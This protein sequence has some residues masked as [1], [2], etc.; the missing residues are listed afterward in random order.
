MTIKKINK[1]KSYGI[2]KDFRW[3]NTIPEFKKYNIINMSKSAKPKNTS[4]GG[5]AEWYDEYL[6]D[7]DTYQEKVIL[8]NLLRVLSLKRGD[9]VIDIACG[10]GYF[11]DRFQKAGAG[12]VGADI[13]KEL[14]A[15][16]KKRFPKIQFHCAPAEKLS[17]AKN[18]VFDIATIILAVQNIADIRGTFRETARIL[19]PGGRL[20]LVMNHPAFR[21]P[22]RSSW[23]WDEEEKIQYRRMDGYLSESS[24]PILAH[25]GQRESESTLSYHRSLQD[26]FK[27]FSKAGFSATRLEEWVSH[28]QSE[29]GPRQKAEN[30][31]RAEFPLFLMLEAK[32]S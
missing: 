25:P 27:A 23:G 21:I 8:P 26:F 29:K 6:A 20:V 14:I 24:V 17:F 7:G 15:I 22:R 31:A 13:S 9:R 28:K 12:V 2:F 19:R 1:I 4:W 10:Q 5:V 32:K 16:A 11:T 3:A 18:S 30:R